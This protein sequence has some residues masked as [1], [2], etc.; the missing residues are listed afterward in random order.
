MLSFRL[1]KR[2]NY[3][4]E[5]KGRFYYYFLKFVLNFAFRKK[6]G[7]QDRGINRYNVGTSRNEFGFNWTSHWTHC[8]LL[9]V[10]FFL[11]T[12]RHNFKNIQNME[13]QKIT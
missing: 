5:K 6:I 9:I 12:H 10:I 7:T 13:N 1:W 4:A 8:L 3:H 11:A 2:L